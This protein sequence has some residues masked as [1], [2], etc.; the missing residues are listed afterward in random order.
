V[1]QVFYIDPEEE[2]TT[3][4][5]RLRKTQSDTV[6]FMI[7]QRALVFASLINMRLLKRESDKVKKQSLIVT[8]DEQGLAVATKAGLVAQSSF[9]D[10][11]DSEDT[12]FFRETEG[13]K[14]HFSDG[15]GHL[16]VV[17]N[18]SITSMPN[19][20]R[21]AK[22][23]DSMRMQKPVSLRVDSEQKTEEFS[24]SVPEAVSDKTKKP[25]S[26]PLRKESFLMQRSGSLGSDE[27]SAISSQF[28][29]KTDP[30]IMNVGDFVDTGGHVKKEEE[31]FQSEFTVNRKTSPIELSMR[32]KQKE[33]VKDL[34]YKKKY[35]VSEEVPSFG[36]SAKPV[37][38]A[39]FA[40]VFLGLSIVGG[41]FAYVFLPKAE[42]GIVPK[43]VLKSED[44]E[45][46]AIGDRVEM[47]GE[48]QYIPID[49]FE[50]VTEK[51]AS[52]P[53]TGK[54]NILNNQKASGTVI[55][56]NEY[57]DQ[58]QSLVSSTRLVTTD[59][60]L[61]R[62]VKSVVVPGMKNENG[63]TVPGQISVEVKADT[64]GAQYNIQPT[65]FS[66][67]GFQGT[68][69]YEKFYAESKSAFSGGGSSIS[70]SELTVSVSDSDEARR[71]II[72]KIK[73]EIVQDTVQKFSGEQKIF[74]EAIQI[75]V[76]ESMSTPSVGTASQNF[77]YFVKAQIRVASFSE[78]ILR[79]TALGSVLKS[80]ESQEKMPFHARETMID[81][82]KPN[83]DFEKK[84]I[85][86][87]FR[88]RTKFLADIQLDVVKKDIIGMKEAVFQAYFKNHPEIEKMDI[89]I[90]PSKF[91]SD[92]PRFADRVK[93]F[94]KE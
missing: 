9:D 69:K 35:S 94:V 58:P 31:M 24:H 59:G 71:N 81:Y 30:K 57:S 61:F 22:S 92:I 68:P 27:Q 34:F 84:T 74:P 47:P 7:P 21:P 48:E 33:T 41:F 55:I 91:S 38:Y 51:R 32:G 56:V 72:E 52:F 76:L 28:F 88:L 67:P 25:F 78:K 20:A 53:A 75:D 5:G 90:S 85:R 83:V 87:P 77:E 63:K 42:I 13:V 66:I 36:I 17:R 4:I 50:A 40:F 1:H 26:S 45:F 6:V 49:F 3:V 80:V 10:S 29:S 19:P 93:V 60:K 12:V 8:Q 15:R 23:M 62:I 16:S 14:P 18:V 54:G 64:F 11:K 79:E 37:R 46:T 44:M 86:I 43:T 39:I 73:E 65:R 82:G 89:A 70:E 2:I